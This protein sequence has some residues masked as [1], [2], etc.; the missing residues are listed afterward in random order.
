MVFFMLIFTSYMTKAYAATWEFRWSNTTV[1]IPVGG[2]L[3][4]YAIIPQA[5]LYRDDMLLSD[6]KINYLR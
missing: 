4:D 2:N 1:V 5:R 3:S 6:A